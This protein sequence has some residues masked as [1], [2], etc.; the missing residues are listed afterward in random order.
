MKLVY[1][2]HAFRTSGVRTIRQ[3][4]AARGVRALHSPLVCTSLKNCSQEAVGYGRIGRVL[5][6]IGTR[7]QAVL[8]VGHD[9]GPATGSRTPAS[10]VT[11]VDRLT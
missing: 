1:V 5:L 6:R 8:K 7:E 2:S 11:K 9:P 3:K 10:V 4:C